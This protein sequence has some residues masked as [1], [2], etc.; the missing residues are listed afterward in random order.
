MSRAGAHAARPEGAER[1]SE[2]KA[3]HALAEPRRRAILRLI[4]ASERSAGDIAASFEV[5][6]PA[7]S[8]H[9]AVLREAGLVTERRDGTRR[10]YSARQEGLVELRRLLEDMWA[11]ALDRARTLAEQEESDNE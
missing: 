1:N 6:R 5:T 9:L 2:D 11:G 8:Q 4:A 7:V 3:F 10:L